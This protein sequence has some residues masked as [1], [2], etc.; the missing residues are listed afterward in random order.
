MGFLSFSLH[1]TIQW[2]IKKITEVY[3]KRFKTDIFPAAVA[4]SNIPVTKVILSPA[5]PFPSVKERGITLYRFTGNN[6]QLNCERT[7]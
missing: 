3:Q 1:H 2:Q 5:G 4:V 6:D 7:V